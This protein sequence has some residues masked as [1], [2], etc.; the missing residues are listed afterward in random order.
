[1][2]RA[3][4]SECNVDPTCH[5][6]PVIRHESLQTIEGSQHR[7][8]TSAWKDTQRGL[9]GKLFIYLFLWFLCNFFPPRVSMC[10]CAWVY[11]CL[12][13]HFNKCEKTTF[14]VCTFSSFVC[15]C[16][17]ACTLLQMCRKH[18][19]Y[20]GVCVDCCICVCECVCPYMPPPITAD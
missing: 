1:M 14:F 2:S 8:M 11:V 19:P 7:K 4:E 17:C 13:V 20:H 10:G 12:G 5:L 18:S 16:V 9:P 15:L 6:S 3:K